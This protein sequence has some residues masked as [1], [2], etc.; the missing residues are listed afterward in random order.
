[1][2]SW[3]FG[4]R[5]ARGGYHSHRMLMNYRYKN[6]FSNV[7]GAVCLTLLLN[8]PMMLWSQESAPRPRRVFMRWGLNGGAAWQTSDV[9]TTGGGGTG[10]T[11]EFPIVENDHSF[12]GTGLRF[13]YLFTGTG[14]RDIT[15][16]YDVA[17]DFTGNGVINGTVDLGI[18]YTSQGSYF[19]NHRTASHN[20]D[21]ELLL[22]LNRL[23]AR[24]GI[25][26]YVWGG[27]GT[28]GFRSKVDQ[29]D[30]FNGLYD[31]SLVDEAGGKDVVLNQLDAIQ[32]RDYET[33]TDPDLRGL[34]RWR[35][36]PSVGVGLGYEFTRWF[37]LVAEYKMTFPLTDGLDG[38]GIIK[39][40]SWSDS[41]IHHYAG[42]GVMFGFLGGGSGGTTQTN[43]VNNYTTRDNRPTIL[44]VEPNT[45][46][47]DLGYNCSG[48]IRARITNISS[49]SLITFYENGSMVSP[50]RYSYD[51]S[52]GMFVARVMLIPRLA[53]TYR[54]DVRNAD[55][56]ASQEIVLRCGA[57]NNFNDAPCYEPQVFITYPQ[58]CPVVV[59]NCNATVYAEVQHVRN[60]ND[61]QVLHQ[62]RNIAANL[63]DFN[64]NNGQM[65]IRLALSP[66]DN[67]LEIVARNACGSNRASNMMTCP[68]QLVLPTV[69]I[70]NP[71]ITPYSSPNCVQNVVARVTGVRSA[72]DISVFQNGALL[73]NA[74]WS[75]N[76]QSKLLNLTVN[77][78]AGNSTQIEILASN[79]SGQAGDMVILSC[80]TQAPP[81]V[82]QVVTPTGGSYN[83]DDCVQ[84]VTARI[85][86]VAGLQDISV[87]KNNQL[88]SSSAWS[89]NPYNQLWSMDLQLQPGQIT[90]LLITARNTVGSAEGQMALRCSEPTV[91]MITICHIPPGNP[92]AVTNLT[93]PESQWQDH[94][95]HGDGRGPCSTTNTT[96]CFEGQT[97][98][99]TSSA[100]E[101]YQA[102]GA[103]VGPCQERQITICHIPPGNPAAAHSMTIS[104][105]AWPAHQAHGDVQGPCS[106]TQIQICYQGNAL[107]IS[108]S[109]WPTYQSLGAT[110]G[111]CPVADITIC[112]LPPGNPAN[113]QTITVSPNAWPAHQ[114][115]GDIQGPCSTQTM[116]VCN[117]GRTQTVSVS[118]WPALQAAGAT[119][120][121]CQTVNLATDIT[122][123]HIPPGNPANAQTMTIPQSAWSG[124]QRHGDVQGPCS[125]TMVDVCLNNQT[126][127]VSQT[128]LNAAIAAGATQGPCPVADITI[129]HLPPGNP[130]NAQT[131]T[132][133][134]NAWP[135]HQAHGDVQGPC[136]S[137]MVQVCLNNQSV[138]VSQTALQ[139]VLA[140]GATQGPCPVAD[141]TICHL[142]PGNPANAQTI[143]VSPNA[144]PAH[145]AHGDVQGPCSSTMVQVCLNNQ[146]V[147]VSQTALQAVLAAGATQG[148]CP[149]P[150]ITICHIPPGNVINEQSITI[151][152]SAWPAHQAHGDVQ[153][154][155]SSN[156]ITICHIPPGNAGNAQTIQISESAWPAHRDRH[157]DTQGPCPTNNGGGDNGGGNN[158]GGNNGGGSNGGNGKP[159][160]GGTTS[161]GSL[162][163]GNGGKPGGNNATS[164]NN[165]AGKPVVTNPAGSGKEVAKPGVKPEEKEGEKTE[166]GK[167]VTKPSSPNPGGGQSSSSKPS[168]PLKG[169]QAP[170]AKP[171]TPVTRPGGGS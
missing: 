106:K 25:V 137:T 99:V 170:A 73:P 147:Q 48:E 24:T 151:P 70:T 5:C 58:G 145:Q 91:E 20:W 85:L 76:A 131:I 50:D 101:A 114:A 13:R 168:A 43:P 98:T 44:L 164:G 31:Y 149:E 165:N 84:H 112:H 10:F 128:V 127:Q 47:A 72:A 18:D 39:T 140:A 171:G 57:P 132:V 117:N 104:P 109:L 107:A 51:V 100:L 122:I 154:P 41:D 65:T 63:W 134:P 155:C 54:I 59:P 158:G 78:T 162:N 139:A 87:K 90:T 66:G 11:I 159:N 34:A 83:G 56:S 148:P 19:A 102:I 105:N 120:G 153:G 62:G 30:F 86:N 40:T 16:S 141:I 94:K 126:V 88:V 36:A 67:R 3:N 64:P 124:H 111:P 12:F 80:F 121:P 53:N 23:R 9:R 95:A 7:W 46:N 144:W 136:S 118:A 14:G 1:M 129:C 138:Q 130:A 97:I 35:F 152:Q 150:Q 133:S 60:R 160:N 79:Q 93:I 89:Y 146:S 68:T 27:I 71:S 169:G 4:T 6:L 37:Q 22:S 26:S 157:G 17:D 142:P 61:I 113:A 28:M 75:Y 96:L 77:L 116:Q 108:E 103:A 92:G 135:A 143:T 161:G 119:Q 123:C 45:P 21:M 32:D 29:E 74:N 15:R 33:Q 8:L 163:P 52:N 115:H 125:S 81:P 110:Q 82:V 55:G 69:E 167:G 2:A 156:K 166:S 49:K 42:L 38:K